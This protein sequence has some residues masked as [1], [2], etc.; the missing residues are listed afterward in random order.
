MATNVGR[1]F[2]IRIKSDE[3]VGRMYA[4]GRLLFEQSLP[5]D[6]DPWIGAR[7]WHRYHGGIRDVR[8][9]GSPEIPD[10]IAMLHDE[11]LTGWADYYDVQNFA[12][13]NNWHFDGEVLTGLSVQTPANANYERLLRYHRPMLEDGKIEYEFYYQPGVSHVAPALDRLA[14]LIDRDAVRVHWCTDGAYDRTGLSPLNVSDEP[15][16]QLASGKVPLIENA[17]NRLK[18]VLVGNDV[19]LVLNDQP[20][21]RRALEPS[22]MRRFGL[23]HFPGQTDAR[24]R[25]LVW[26]GEWPKQLPALQDQ[27][28]AD[29][30]FLTELDRQAAAMQVVQVDFTNGREAPATFQKR[31]DTTG[32]AV[33]VYQ[34]TKDGL[35]SIQQGR[36]ADAYRFQALA[37]PH[38][39]QGDFDIVVEF[40]RLQMDQVKEQEKFLGVSLAVGL[41]SGPAT[42]I[43]FHARRDSKGHIYLDAVSEDKLKDGSTRWDTQVFQQEAT[44]GR[45]RIARRGTNVYYLFASGDSDQFRLYRT[46]ALTDSPVKAGSIE[47]QTVTWGVGSTSVVWKSLL[48]RADE[49]STD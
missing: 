39:L 19:E 31:L 21:F 35:Q 8:I 14:M 45:L 42:R 37:A 38:R 3:G 32:G 18:L 43:Y 46:Q 41:E 20:I 25:N 7:S 11:G 10:A 49:I 5:A 48:L 27:E 6:G 13:L 29:V 9:T 36:T 24:V 34:V 22:N 4:N 23:F 33:S 26:A 28:L 30:E 40:D 47:L 12:T 2:H 44:A 15:Q 1:W 17:W 16:G